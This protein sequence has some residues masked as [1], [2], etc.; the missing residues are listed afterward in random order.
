METQG[1]ENRD[2][3][4]ALLQERKEISVFLWEKQ[5]MLKIL[6][7]S[8]KG[9]VKPEW[10]IEL[11]DNI[12]MSARAPAHWAAPRP[13]HEFKGHPPAP[14]FEQMRAG[15]L[16]ALHQ[17]N[18]N[19]AGTERQEAADELKLIKFDRTTTSASAG[20]STTALSAAGVRGKR[21][22]G[23][24]EDEDAS[25]SRKRAKEE[26]EEGR[27]QEEP[28]AARARKAAAVNFGLD[29]DSSSDSD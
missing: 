20:V 21:G 6:R 11:A 16:E 8:G 18:I 17:K 26:D 14:Q 24:G 2:E 12:T 4:K 1:L 7:E 28:A 25:R 15:K 5:E 29:N 10:L 3:I 19:K 23:N 27:R 22:R 13:L 9:D